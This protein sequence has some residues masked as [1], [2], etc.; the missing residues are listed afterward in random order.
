[1][2]VERRASSEEW[3]VEASGGAAGRPEAIL[4][5]SGRRFILRTHAD[6]VE[7]AAVLNAQ[8]AALAEAALLSRRYDCGK[9]TLQ[10]TA[11][12]PCL[13]LPHKDV[14][15]ACELTRAR[16]ER[17]SFCICDDDD[18]LPTGPAD[19]CPVHGNTYKYVLQEEARL[20]ETQRARDAAAQRAAAAEARTQRLEAALQRIAGMGT[21]SGQACSA[22]AQA[23]LTR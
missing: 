18:E 1:M 10:K 14:C 9:T 23:V 16:F 20:V 21:E 3:Q 15:Y 12:V 7:L 11:M 13:N 5:G 2:T 4:G 8:T 17:N 19:Y 6:A 22:V